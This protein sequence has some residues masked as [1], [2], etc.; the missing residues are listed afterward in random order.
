M[1]LLA[2]QSKCFGQA[3]SIKADSEAGRDKIDCSWRCA[4]RWR[5]EVGIRTGKGRDGSE[6]PGRS[7]IAPDS[8][9]EGQGA[10]S[11]NPNEMEM[12]RDGDAAS[13]PADGEIPQEGRDEKPVDVGAAPGGAPDER[14]VGGDPAFGDEPDGE[15][16]PGGGENPGLRR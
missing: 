11:G 3:V 1:P 9:K 7:E 10:F 14:A 15:S 8:A 16:V 13:A 4:F 6:N 12:H 5:T 2:P